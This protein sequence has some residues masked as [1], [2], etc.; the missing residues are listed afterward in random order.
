MKNPS[1]IRYRT[2][3]LRCQR[4]QDGG[5]HLHISHLNLN[6]ISFPKQVGAPGGDMCRA[7]DLEAQS[8]IQH[9]SVSFGRVVRSNIWISVLNE[10]H[11]F[12]VQQL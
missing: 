1:K 2:F 3:Q 5:K 8:A 11:P 9:D 12:T 7:H 4:A 6:E 10:L